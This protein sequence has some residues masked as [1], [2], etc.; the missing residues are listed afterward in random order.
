MELNQR[1]TVTSVYR[2]K[3]LHPCILI[4][5]IIWLGPKAIFVPAPNLKAPRA[6]TSTGW[7][8]GSVL[9]WLGHLLPADDTDWY[10]RVIFST[11]RRLGPILKWYS[12]GYIKKKAS[13]TQSYMMHRWDGNKATCETGG[14]G[15]ESSRPH[16]RIY[17]WK[18]HLTCD[19]RGSSIVFI[20]WATGTKWLI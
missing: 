17:V 9:K 1:P 3:I 10:W 8:F 4:P 13:P 18:N 16:T 5:V 11:G 7:C 14:H 20:F 6:N 2:S 19:Y 15:F 12:M